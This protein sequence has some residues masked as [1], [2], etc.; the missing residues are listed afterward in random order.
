MFLWTFVPNAD[1][2]LQIN[3][4]RDNLHINALYV[5]SC[6]TQQDSKT[7]N[8]VTGF[9]IMDGEKHIFVLEGLRDEA[10]QM[11]WE[12]LPRAKKQGRK[13]VLLNYALFWSDHM[14]LSL[15]SNLIGCCKALQFKVGFA[16]YFTVAQ[17]I[18][19]VTKNTLEVKRKYPIFLGNFI[20]L[21]SSKS[22]NL[23]PFCHSAFLIIWKN[24]ETEGVYVLTVDPFPREGDMSFP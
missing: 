16:I 12:T 23:T 21:V 17:N 2:D 6:R 4:V 8:I 9:Q 7:L 13:N 20:T 14:H 1:F 15:Q 19:S 11:L 24:V 10:I 5:V 18:W 3:Q 22:Q